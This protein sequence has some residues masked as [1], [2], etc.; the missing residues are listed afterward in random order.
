MKHQVGGWP[1]DFD[2]TEPGD[3]QK[4][5]KKLIRD[6]TQGY[7]SSTKDLVVGAQKWIRQN[8]Q[9]DLFEEYFS[10]EQPEHMSETI[11]TKTIMIFKDPNQT[12]R[13]VTKIA[14]HPETQ[15]DLRVGVSYAILRFQ[16]MPQKMPLNSYIWHLNNPNFPE[17]TLSPPS[18]LCTMVFNHKNPDIIVGGSYNGSLSSFD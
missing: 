16:Q 8:N 17:K 11:N 3:Q 10:G 12:K 18:A 13:A 2:Y 9:I 1:R 14:W 15:T 5:Y 4:Y 6:P 7:A